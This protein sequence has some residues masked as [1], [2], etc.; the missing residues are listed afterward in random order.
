[1]LA[2]EVQEIMQT[3]KQY[4]YDVP[5][6]EILGAMNRNLALRCEAAAKKDEFVLTLGGDHGLASGSITGMLRAHPDLRVVWIDAHG[7]CNIPETSPSLNYHGMPMAHCLGW[8]EHGSM[9]GFDWLLPLMKPENLCYIGLR[10]LDIGEIALLKKHNIKV[11]TPYDIELNGG[12]GPVMKQVK[13]YL[14][15]DEEN[16]PVH[17]S[18]D[19][20]GCDPIFAEGTGTRARCG[21]S[22]RESHFIL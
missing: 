6:I 9:R 15:L 1:M 11:Y 7:D 20:D 4:K 21:L 12:I 14:R 17:I 19:I 3:T 10:D 2:D 22:V 8:I 18:W 13:E 16:A 5:N